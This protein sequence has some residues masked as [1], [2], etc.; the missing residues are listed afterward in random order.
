MTISRRKLQATRKKNDED[1]EINLNF[2]LVLF[3][4]RV[5]CIDANINFIVC[6]THTHSRQYHIVRNRLCC[7]E[8]TPA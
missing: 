6:V 8:K 7:I 3:R 2:F 4:G 5:K 1:S